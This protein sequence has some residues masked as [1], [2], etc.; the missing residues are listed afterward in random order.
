MTPRTPTL[1]ALLSGDM[2]RSGWYPAERRRDVVSW[3]LEIAVGVGEGALL[4]AGDQSAQATPLRQR[5]HRRKPRERHQVR[6]IETSRNTM[7]DLH[8][9][10]TLLNAANRSFDKTDSRC[11]AGHPASATRGRTSSHRWIRVEP[12]AVRAIICGMS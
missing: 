6:I 3:S 7:T 10:D 5:H 11:T 2:D 1:S 9:P 8:L 12:S 4:T